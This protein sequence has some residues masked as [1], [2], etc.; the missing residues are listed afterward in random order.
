MSDPIEHDSQSFAERMKLLRSNYANT[1]PSKLRE[2]EQTWRQISEE[3]NFD[4]STLKNF[5][6]MVHKLAGSGA[7]YGYSRL[8]RLMQKVENKVDQIADFPEDSNRLVLDIQSLLIT[9]EL[10]SQP[11]DVDSVDEPEQVKPRVRPEQIR[12]LFALSRGSKTYD[13]AA[14]ME[15][16]GFKIDYCRQKDILKA[17]IEFS[18]HVLFFQ[19]NLEQT[20][21]CPSP[22]DL[23]GLSPPDVFLLSPQPSLDIRVRAFREGAREVLYDPPDISLLL[24]KIDGCFVDKSTEP[25]KVLIIDDD[26]LLASFHAELL[27]QAGLDTIVSTC[28][29]EVEE[30]LTHFSPD[31]ILMDLHMPGYNGIEMAAALRQDPSLYGVPIIFISVEQDIVRHLGAIKVGGDD[32]LIKPVAAP[33]LLASVETRARRGRELRGLIHQDGLTGL[34]NHVSIDDRLVQSM[35]RSKRLG[36]ELSIAMIDLDYFKKVN[37]NYGHPMGDRVLI[38]LARYL[39]GRLRNSD[40]IGRYGGEEFMLLLPDTPLVHAKSLVESLRESFSI[41]NHNT[42]DNPVKVT[43]SSGIA[44]FPEVQTTKELIAAADSALYQ[45]KKLG[46]NR[47]VTVA[48]FPN[49]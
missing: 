49:K 22:R 33:Y 3:P 30:A 17:S 20:M 41:I 11:D 25:F 29:K 32:F 23:G 4:I 35:A 12:I 21:L 39:K 6:T 13:V 48:D 28:S 40:I 31:V 18:P 10:E 9:L 34:L 44:S 47:T 2:L 36:T 19:E 1:L 27:A 5:R 42:K 43:F 26:P 8:S 24:N 7:P 15:H 46:R 37:D 14:Q 45:A 38:D 16:Y